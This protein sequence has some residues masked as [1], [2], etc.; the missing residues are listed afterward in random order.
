M[1]MVKRTNAT[2]EDFVDM[3]QQIL[4][5]APFGLINDIYDRKNMIAY[6]YFW[7]SDY[8]PEEWEEW[9]VR[10]VSTKSNKKGIS[11][12]HKK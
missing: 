7:D 2:Y 5:T 8:I 10:P 3:R 4:D 9:I 12:E 11:E 1:R 6:L